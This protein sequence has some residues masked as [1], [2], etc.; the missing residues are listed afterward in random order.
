[1]KILIVQP[2][3][4]G[5]SLFITPVIRQLKKQL[6]PEG[7]DLILGSR[8]QAVFENNPNVS[9]VF[10]VDKDKWRSQ[11]WWKTWQEKKRLYA[12]LKE[13]RY[14]VFIDFSLRKEYAEWLKGLNIPK[15]LGFDHKGRGRYLNF[16]IPLKEG[17]CAKH[18]VEYYCQLLDFLNIKIEDKRLEYYISTAAEEKAK[19]ILEKN[20]LGGKKIICLCLGGGSSW[21]KDAFLKHWPVENFAALLEMLYRDYPHFVTVILGS[22]QERNLGDRFELLFRHRLL[23]LSGILDLATSAAIL[24]A[25]ALFIANDGGLVHLARSLEVPLVALYGPTDPQ[26]YGPYPPSAKACVIF[27][28]G[29]ACRPCYANFAYRD[30][31]RYNRCLR[32]LSP[33]EVYTKIKNTCQLNSLLL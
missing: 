19:E 24:K 14:E 21:G 13:N 11:G 17:F 26:V 20:G 22:R 8:S 25:C 23:N 33:Q 2:F 32:E 10:I 30:D 5:D 3:G 12:L 31:C 29:L 7:I 18:V 27:K 6:H 4:I 1:M 15:R 9:Q 16:R 28:E